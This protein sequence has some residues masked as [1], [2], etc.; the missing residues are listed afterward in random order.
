MEFETGRNARSVTTVWFRRRYETIMAEAKD[1]RYDTGNALCDA[2]RFLSDAS[3]AVMPRDVAHQIVE[4]K[5]NFWGGV[6]WC[7]EKN[8]K[9]IDEALEGSDR[10]RE[11]WRRER[12]NGSARDFTEP[13]SVNPS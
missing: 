10:L 13:E 6:R 5:K 1:S 4:M 2:L 3:L 7:A 12:T 8:M 11:E 9:W